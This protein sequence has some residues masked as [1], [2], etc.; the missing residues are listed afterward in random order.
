MT[1]EDAAAPGPCIPL[2]LE[3]NPLQFLGRS[4]SCW[5]TRGASRSLQPVCKGLRDLSSSHIYHRGQV[6]PGGFHRAAAVLG[7]PNVALTP[8]TWMLG[9]A[10]VLL[11]ILSHH[12]QVM[13]CGSTW[14]AR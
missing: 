5:Q 4:H 6:Y 3:A 9:N 13:M 10:G 2:M 7:A 14:E 11:Q 1:A 12:A 8:L